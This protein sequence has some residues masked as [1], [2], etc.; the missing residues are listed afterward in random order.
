MLLAI[1]I[2]NTQTVIGLFGDE[3]DA[4]AGDRHDPP[5]RGPVSAAETGLLD[6]WRI[7]TNAERTSDEH[8]L[9]VQ[10]FLGF[11]G[12]SFDDD[13]D[14]I[15]ISSVVPRTTAAFREMTERYFGF[16]P[17]VIEAG[18][19]T[20]LPIL[21]ENPREV[22]ADRIANAVAALDLVG[23]PAII[24][25]FGTA[26]TYDALSSKGEYLGGAIAPGV[27]ISL[28]ALYLRAAALRRVELVEPRNVIGRTTVES[29]QSGAVFG[30]AGQVDGICR[31]LAD[32]LGD[33]EV[34][35]TGG[36]AE[37]IAPYT[38]SIKRVEPWLTLHGLRLVWERNQ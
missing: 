32:E 17:V 22:G 18:V 4:D 7:S 13:I 24:I 29:I 5:R 31:R 21:T 26:T 30:F 12:F 2:G 23:G 3:G 36:L 28:D 8:A 35:A 33:P 11:H 34:V 14:G 37:L 20:G 9:V 27:E 16:R 19:R 1:D 15:A 38:S 6:H 25:D 10:E